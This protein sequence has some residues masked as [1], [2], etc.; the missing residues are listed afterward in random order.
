MLLEVLGEVEPLA[1]LGGVG[2][3]AALVTSVA[4]ELLMP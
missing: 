2:G 1:A 4:L 3:F